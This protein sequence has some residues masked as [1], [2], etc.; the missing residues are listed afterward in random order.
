[1]I[2]FIADIEF[3]WGFQSKVV[4]YSKTSP[5]FHYP[6]P[7]TILGALAE[8][9]ARQYNIGEE[10]GKTIIPRLASNLLALGIRP[11]NC[12][13]VKFSDINRLIAS[14]ITRSIKYPSPRD[15]YRSFDAPATG[16]TILTP[17]DDNPPQIRIYAVFR[18]AAIIIDNI[19]TKL[20]SDYFWN[21]HRLG[22]KES[23]VSAISVQ[24]F[25]PDVI[26]E[27]TVET[28][29]SFPL[30]E[31]V[32]DAGY[33]ELKWVSEDLINPFK[34]KTYDE[35]DNPVKN[36]IMGHSIVRYKLPIKID[37]AVQ[38]VYRIALEKGRCCV[39]TMGGEKV[40]GLCQR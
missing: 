34:V 30:M 37:P 23:R 36:Y 1:M 22:T 13:P 16:K 4:G 6:P 26:E 20:H 8:S 18:D 19:E 9:I 14:R 32:N 31:G 39:Y 3:V 7:T 2:G 11:I 29:Y 24:E 5:S 25:K 15:P 27:A 40:L 17:L 12:I 35:K 33:V 10:K 21:I 38:P 28:Q